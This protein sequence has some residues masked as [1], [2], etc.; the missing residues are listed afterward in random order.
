M[1]FD[2]PVV[3]TRDVFATGNRALVNVFARRGEAREHR[4]MV[5]VDAAVAQANPNLLDA[6]RQYA[7]AH[8]GALHLAADPVVVPGGEAI[9]NNLEAVRDMVLAL[10][11]ERMDRQSFVVIV[12]GGAVLDAVG[13]AASVV[14][15]GLRQVRVPT[16]VLAQNDA[17]IGVKNAI[18][19]GGVKNLL[20]C[21]APPFAVINDFAFLETLP[22]G[23]WTDGIAEAFKVALI[24]DALFFDELC[25]MAP[26]LRTRDMASMERLVIRC[27]ELH[28]EHIR[29][30]GDPFELGRARPLDFGH[31]SAHRLETMS[32]N[33]LRHGEA[34]ALGI[35]LDACYALQKDWLAPEAFDKLERGLI[36]AGFALWNPLLE[37]RDASGRLLILDGLRDFQ[38]HLGGELTITMPHGVGACFDL[39]EVDPATVELAIEV[40]RTRHGAGVR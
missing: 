14:H 36:D 1:S 12:G 8:R 5:F 31:W 23:Q 6:I 39:H 27:A 22:Q 16:T 4:C 34:V 32:F 15:R 10:T 40:L 9:K 18:N 26:R 11:R 24:K 17:G 20:G 29:S 13:F 38:E 30:S 33:E 19:H 2:Y 35:T 3:F 7:S 37:A 25:L 21:F 28:L